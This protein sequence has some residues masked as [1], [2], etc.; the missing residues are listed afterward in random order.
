VTKR[1]LSKNAK[2]SVVKSVFIPILTCGHVKR[3]NG[4]DGIFAKSSKCIGVGAGKFLGVWKIFAQISPNLLASALFQ[5]KALQAPFL[6]KFTPNLPKFPPNFP[7]KLGE[8]FRCYVLKSK[9]IQWFCEGVH[10]FCPNVH[11]F[12]PDF[13]WFCPDFHQ[14]KRFG[15]HLHP[16]LLYQ[17]LGV[18]LRDKDHR[19]ETRKARD[20]KPLLRIERSQLW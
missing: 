1:E 20:V 9:H 17:C 10:T 2:L 8:N 5:V 12:C 3:V 19:S 7:E 6:P 13:K 11:R 4:I 15:V 18:T 14:I 16:R